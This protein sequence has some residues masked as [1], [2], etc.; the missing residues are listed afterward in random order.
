MCLH[1]SCVF[2]VKL[3]CTT[4]NITKH[5]YVCSG[6]F[7][8]MSLR[9]RCLCEIPDHPREETVLLCRGCFYIHFSYIFICTPEQKCSC[10]SAE[11]PHATDGVLLHWWVSLLAV[12]VMCDIQVHLTV[13]SAPVCSS[14]VQCRI[15][16]SLFFSICTHASHY[17]PIDKIP[18]RATSHSNAASSG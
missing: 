17:V 15:L 14:R 10:F 4:M 12:Y 3:K 6:I 1:F 13:C 11:I 7:G 2:L 5:V 18:L 16:F 9:T 8:S